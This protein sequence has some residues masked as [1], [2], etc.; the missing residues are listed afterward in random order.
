MGGA[1]TEVDE[2]T[3]NIIIECANFDMYSVRRT[4]MHHGLFTDAVTRFTKGQSPLQNLAVLAKIVDEIRRSAEGRAASLVLDDNHVSSEVQE[5]GNVHPPVTT[6]A[7]FINVRLGLDL[8]AEEIA[9]LLTNVE[10][11]VQTQDNSLTIKAPFWRTDIAIPEDIVEEVGRLYGYDRLPLKL[12][13][14]DLTPPPRNALLDLKTRVREVLSAAG[15]NELLTYSFTHGNLLDKVGQDAGQAFQIANAL[16]PDLQ[17]YR[18]SLT[19][20]LL[21]KVHPNIKSGNNAFA[22][23]ELGKVHHIAMQDD[24]GLP[25]EFER[26]ALVF[27]ADTKTA[28][29]DYA[30]AAYYQARKYLM[31]LLDAFGV[32]NDVRWQPLAEAQFGDRAVIEQMTRPYDPHRAAVLVK[33][34]LIVGAV[35][36]YK[37]SVRRALKLPDFAAGFETFH[38]FL[39]AGRG[40]QYTPL[41]RFP[42]VEQD[43]CLRVA[44][45]MSYDQVYN[46]VWAKLAEVQPEN[47]LPALGPVDIYQRPDDPAHKQIT[48]RFTIA[49]YE[50]TLTDDEVSK[51]LAHVAEAA[52]NE[53]Q[54]ERI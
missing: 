13:G 52:H 25:K 36:E 18:L 6:S 32:I 22:L 27:A 10:F 38:S 44:A 51:L 28:A 30:G 4:A 54:A 50:R 43:I 47:T 1:D 42:K 23:F 26:I 29:A 12:P 7:E 2:N 34:D 39:Q 17:Y 15:A 33:G 11:D 48:L 49:S 8:P 19:P 45:N 31:L 46:F 5:R 16:S 37:P 21:E 20:S 40:T 3:K 53:L 41:P 14:R 35:G 24:E 9:G